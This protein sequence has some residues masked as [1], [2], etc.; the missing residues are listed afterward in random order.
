VGGDREADRVAALRGDGRW[1][2]AL[3]LVDDPLVRADLLNEQALFTGSA[4]ARAEAV[5]ELDRAE[6]LLA[7]GRGRVLHARFLVDRAA[8]DPAELE[9][10][11]RGLAVA[12]RLGDRGLEAQAL[13]WVGLVHQ[14]VRG[15]HVAG[16]PY[17]ERSYELAHELGDTVT[18]SYAVRHLGFADTA[19]GLHERAW[20]RF[21]ESVELRRAAGFLP[22]VA[23]GL[24]TL[25][26]VAAEQ[27]RPDEARALLEEA[28][29]LAE[30]VGAEPFLRLIEA[31]LAEL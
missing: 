27:G 10:F 25:G 29:G 3:A 8:E 14:V 26:E 12:E 21:R 5:A 19:A 18:M 30:Q 9:A 2:E 16:T 1:R 6:A 17:F 24:F 22:G 23:A 7:L 13:F 15:D 20:E 11:E 31:A 4:D 28:R